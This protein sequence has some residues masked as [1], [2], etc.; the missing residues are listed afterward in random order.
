MSTII[1]SWPSKYN[2]RLT[3]KKVFEWMEQNIDKKYFVLEC[4]VGSGKSL[5]GLTL[6]R[7]LTKHKYGNSFI[8]TPQKILQKQYEN[9]EL[10]DYNTLFSL[11]GKSNY[12]C[13]KFNVP[14]SLG[15]LFKKCGTSCTHAAAIAS[16][17]KSNN[18]IL[19]YILALLVFNHTKI[20]KKR[21]LMICDEAHNL[22]DFLVGFN[23]VNITKKRAEK[24]KVKYK[25]FTNIIR[26]REWLKKEYLPNV[27]EELNKLALAVENIK[28]DEI[29]KDK[30]KPTDIKILKNFESLD[31]HCSTIVD[32]LRENDE[33]IIQNEYILISDDI[34]LQF[35]PIFGRNNFHKI[36]NDMASKFLF[37][38]STILNHKEY[39][40]NLG[41]PLNETTFLS[42][43]SEFPKEN[44]QCI[45]VGGMKMNY[46]WKNEENQKRRERYL[47]NINMILNIHQQEKGIIHTGNF[48][49]AEFI[50]DHLKNQKTFKIFHHNPNSNYD[51]GDVIDR[52]IKYSGP[53]ILISPSITEGL[54]LKDDL[55]RF[56]II[57]KMPFPYLGDPWIKKRLELSQDW[58]NMKT[59]KDIIQGAG[60]IVRSN[61]DYGST[62]I[63]DESWNYLFFKNSSMFPKWWKEAYTVL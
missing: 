18:V 61:T 3:Q 9:E 34:K 36:L 2:P 17:V 27:T 1:N 11:Y 45:Y 62:Y 57:G 30:I 4:P 6:S 47:N 25:K 43:S 42:V 32:F 24:F 46:N 10:I 40:K 15:S 13:H 37:M 28:I 41:I 60:R 38:S 12:H 52:Y 54:D 16:A 49:I 53:S 5:I 63:I 58:Y 22:E 14:C 55:G 44:R 31:S 50:V 8:L 21:S 23:A 51:R 7:Y 20:F 59:I 39:C 19:N 35:K 29:S 33:K 56:V 26:A 48:K